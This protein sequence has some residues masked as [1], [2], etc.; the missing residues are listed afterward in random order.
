MAKQH[1]LHDL[2]NPGPQYFTSWRA[3]LVKVGTET[4]TG[5][6]VDA[7]GEVVDFRKGKR[8]GLKAG[9]WVSVMNGYR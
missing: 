7:D 6:A 8:K 1:I 3:L 5:Y 9:T 2:D 4:I